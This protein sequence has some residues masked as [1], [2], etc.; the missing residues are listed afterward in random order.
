MVYFIDRFFPG[1]IQRHNFDHLS[2]VFW[3]S[4]TIHPALSYPS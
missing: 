4:V 2:S 1:A 3:R